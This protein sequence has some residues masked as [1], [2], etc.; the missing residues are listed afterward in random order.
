MELARDRIDSVL[1]KVPTGLGSARGRNNGRPA[2]TLVL[3][4]IEGS[5]IWM[6]ADTAV[7][8]APLDLRQREYCLKIEVAKNKKALIGFAG[9]VRTGLDAALVAA[10]ETSHESTIQFLTSTSQTS[11]VEFCYAY[12]NTDGPRLVHVACGN[13]KTVSTLHLGNHSA[14][15]DFQ[16]IRHGK[17]DSY[18]PLALKTF[19]FGTKFPLQSKH[20]GSAIQCMIE[21]FAWRTDHDV[22]GWASPYILTPDGAYFCDYCFAVSDPIFDRIAPGSIVPH[23]TA[24]EG[25]S[26]LSV[27]ELGDQEGEV[28]YWPQ[29]PGGTIY[30]RTLQGHSVHRLDGAPEEFKQRALERLGQPVSIWIGEQPPGSINKVS[31]LRDKKTGLINLV[32][33]KHESS[34]TFSAQNLQT[35]FQSTATIDMG[36]TLTSSDFPMQIEVSK[37]R[38]SASVTVHGDEDSNRTLSLNASNLDKLIH[39]LSKARANLLEQIPVDGPASGQEMLVQSDP[40]WRTEQSPLTNT[41]GIY[42]RLRHQGYGWL[43]FIL[44]YAEA[45]SLGKWLRENSEDHGAA[46]S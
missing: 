21:L 7:T 26:S 31:I 4:S 13:T 14:F 3:A 35:P 18:A 37:D 20:L 23:G 33:N 45:N 1:H 44:P 32:V 17:I 8:G 30:Q 19:L 38:Q 36:P 24:T 46:G 27:T 6:V 11:D 5:E 42:L 16:K 39:E 40:A 15:E 41:P 2:L 12:F 34:L 25:G 43:A 28:V 9:D 22:G 29:V 10:S